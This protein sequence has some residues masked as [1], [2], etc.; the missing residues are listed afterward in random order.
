[1][2]PISS[3][4]SPDTTG[5]ALLENVDGDLDP[6]GGTRR[7]RHLAQRLDHP[8]AFADE[9]THVRRIGVHEQRVRTRL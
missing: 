9:P 8:A 5:P 3:R 6:L 2:R 1:M 4:V 7:P